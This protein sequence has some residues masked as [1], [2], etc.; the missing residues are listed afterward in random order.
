MHLARRTSIIV[1]LSLALALF[2]VGSA[3]PQ[4]GPGDAVGSS[5]LVVSRASEPAPTAWTAPS[6]WQVLVTSWYWN[7]IALAHARGWAWSF[8]P[9]LAVSFTRPVAVPR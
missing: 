1:V 7:Q 6:L 5:S 3:F 8:A 4:V 2:C 9:A